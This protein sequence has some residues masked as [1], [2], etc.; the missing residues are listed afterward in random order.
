M[1]IGQAVLGKFPYKDGKIPQYS[2]PYL[3]VGV[4]TQNIELLVV[5][6]LA[7]KEHKLSYP[8]NHLINNF[9]P[10]FFKKSFVKL[11]SLFS[12]PLVQ[13]S[14]LIVLQNGAM[15]DPNELS[16]ILAKLAK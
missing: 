6:S 9:N 16:L 12:I 15:L 13:S 7:G 2:R 5:S 11:D 14:S 8:S 10:P 3:V 1:K 4:T